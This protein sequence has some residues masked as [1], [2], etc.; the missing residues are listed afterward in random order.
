MSFCDVNNKRIVW[1]CGYTEYNL[2]ELFAI[3]HRIIEIV[4]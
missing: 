2:R 3:I 1:P 4:S